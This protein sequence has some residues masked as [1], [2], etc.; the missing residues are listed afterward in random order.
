MT[1]AS[2]KVF[3]ILSSISVGPS[4][5]FEDMNVAISLSYCRLIETLTLKELEL[6]AKKGYWLLLDSRPS[7]SGRFLRQ[8]PTHEDRL[9]HYL[10]VDRPIV[11][12]Q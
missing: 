10:V 8:Y 9:R 4:S 3:K 1:A 5:T 6:Q 7:V 2:A 12:K 11:T